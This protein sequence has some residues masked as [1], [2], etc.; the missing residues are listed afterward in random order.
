MRAQGSGTIVNIASGAGYQPTPYL[1]AYGA[2]KSY[3]RMFS[4]AIYEE[5]RSHGVRVL[6]VSPGDTETPMNP[7]ATKGKRQPSQVVDTAWKAMTGRAPSVVDGGKN[8]LLAGLSRILP[9]RTGLRIAG[10]M[11]RDRA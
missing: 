9:T 6:A 11:F 1:A 5:N 7:G 4:E 10:R 8:R 3:V 2:S